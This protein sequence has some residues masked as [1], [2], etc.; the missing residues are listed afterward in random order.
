MGN[1]DGRAALIT[2]GGSGIGLGAARRLAANG[3]HVTIAG[4]TEARLAG[5]IA[6]IAAQAA[7]GA[8]VQYAVCDVTMED[9]VVAAVARAAEPSG[10]LDI[11][12]ACAGGSM[13]L[14]PILNAEV[15][16]WR[17]T[18]DLNL[19]GTMLSIKHAAAR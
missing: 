4:R 19:V 5:A 3:A 18:L 1:L 17:A 6:D 7:P 13:T 10:G 15:N 9:D 2:G 8:T 16:G 14:G 11:L 12:F